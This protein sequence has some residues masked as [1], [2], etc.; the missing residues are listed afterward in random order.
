[1]IK[2]YIDVRASKVLWF[3]QSTQNNSYFADVVFFSQRSVKW[4][5]EVESDRNGNNNACFLPL[6][7]LRLPQYQGL[8]GIQSYWLFSSLCL[9]RKLFL[10]REKQERNK[11]RQNNTLWLNFTNRNHLDKYH[12]KNWLYLI[13]H[14]LEVPS[15]TSLTTGQRFITIFYVLN[16]HIFKYF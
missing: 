9:G 16:I 3:R 8:L 10:L 6:T 2:E 14:Q 13:F 4:F 12:I 1:M 5:I 7:S 11:I 15:E